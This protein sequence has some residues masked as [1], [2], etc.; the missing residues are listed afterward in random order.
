MISYETAKKILKQ[1]KIKIEN[2]QISAENSYNRVVAENIY[3]PYD[4]PSA[5]NAAFDGYAINSNE[6]SW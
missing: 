4:Y 5:D 3:S 2:E 1:A 6:I